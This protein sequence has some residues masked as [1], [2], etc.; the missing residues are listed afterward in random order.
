MAAEILF[1]VSELKA[2]KIGKSCIK[3]K[4]TPLSLS[5]N[6]TDSVSWVFK[7]KNNILPDEAKMSNDSSEKLRIL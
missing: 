4:T 2:R 1:E 7:N 5:L 3:N 6:K